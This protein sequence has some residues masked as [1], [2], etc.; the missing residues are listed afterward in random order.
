[1]SDDFYEKYLPKKHY[2]L[3]VNCK[4]IT[5][6]FIER[7]I[8]DLNWFGIDDTDLYK[9][10]ISGKFGAIKDMI[11][12]NEA[13]YFNYAVKIK[14]NVDNVTVKS[15]TNIDNFIKELRNPIVDYWYSPLNLIDNVDGFAYGES[16][17]SFLA[18]AKL[19]EEF[20]EKYKDVINWD[21]LSANPHLTMEFWSK[22][23]DKIN[24]KYIWRNFHVTQEF[25][26]KHID[27]VEKSAFSQNP[28]FSESFYE[29]HLDKI[30]WDVLFRNT[31]LSRE[32]LAKY[33]DR[34]TNK[35]NDYLRSFD[36]FNTKDEIDMEVSIKCCNY[37]YA[38][39][40][41]IPEDLFKENP[42]LISEDCY[43]RNPG[44]SPD[45][46]RKHIKDV[47][48]SRYL[49]ENT[50][51]HYKQKTLAKTKKYSFDTEWKIHVKI[52]KY[53]YTCYKGIS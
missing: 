16:I 15:Y 23:M 18:N 31:G 7:H 46:F 10:L 51:T 53:D 50:F 3:L 39:N 36:E 28:N 33:Q 44:L 20:I 24:M 49:S 8:N 2:P 5:S 32:F 27:Q 21:H 30:D 12:N 22:H 35:A 25:A 48:S 14:D 29:Q 17:L 9:V 52:P 37:I 13:T 19:S 4:F 42:R 41:N 6:N 11:R 40:P 45:F 43:L 47:T 38:Q 26:E 34:M 1:M